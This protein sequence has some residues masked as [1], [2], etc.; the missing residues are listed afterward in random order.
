MYIHINMYMKIKMIFVQTSL[1]GYTLKYEYVCA[2]IWICIWIFMYMQM[3][4]NC[5]RCPNENI[6]T[7]N[8]TWQDMIWVKCSKPMHAENFGS[9]CLH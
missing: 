5:V 8:K 1:C 6:L 3:Y 7:Q 4:L 2:C 9:A